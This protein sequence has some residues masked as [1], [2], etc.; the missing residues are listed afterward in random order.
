MPSVGHGCNE[1]HEGNIVATMKANAH[2][3]SRWYEPKALKIRRKRS[4]FSLIWNLYSHVNMY[5][6]FALKYKSERN[7]ASYNRSLN[8]RDFIK[9]CYLLILEQQIYNFPK[10][11][12][13]LKRLCYQT[14][15]PTLPNIFASS[16]WH[17]LIILF[18]NFI[19]CLTN[20]IP[21]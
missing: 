12:A 9:N 21:R 14:R 16:L 8:Q 20:L 2:E 1:G 19:G 3:F 13:L 15:F 4:L 6:H 17:H 11:I 18:Y 10:V 7:W 5:T